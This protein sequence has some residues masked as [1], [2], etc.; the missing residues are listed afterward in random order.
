MLPTLIKGTAG[1][2]PLRLLTL[3]QLISHL[4]VTGRVRTDLGTDS[5]PH[6]ESVPRS[7]LTLPVTNKCDITIHTIIQYAL[8]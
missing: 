8:L 2:L 5:G 4:L 3:D 7:V 1:P 6:P